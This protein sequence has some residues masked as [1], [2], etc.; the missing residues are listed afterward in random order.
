M[1]EKPTRPKQPNIQERQPP[2]TLQELISRYDLDNTKIYDFL[3][4]LIDKLNDMKLICQN[5]TQISFP[6]W[7]S[8]CLTRSDP[9]NIV[10]MLFGTEQL[11]K[12]LYSL[13][14][15][16]FSIMTYG[17]TNSTITAPVSAVTSINRRDW[18]FELVLA[19]S[20]IEGATTGGYH[21]VAVISNGT[22]KIKSE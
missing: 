13:E 4:E 5:K 17:T 16:S 19:R 3:D 10:L 14:A 11:K 7:H 8:M 1:I 9:N 6:A 12:G 18:G 22:L 20:G 21:G 15:G 2:R